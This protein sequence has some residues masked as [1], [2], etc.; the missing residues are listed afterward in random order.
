MADSTRAGASDMPQMAALLGGV[1]AQEVIKITTRQYV[2]LNGT[3]I[4][5]G[6]K[7]TSQTVN[8]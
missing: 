5:D 4:F 7:S 8:F 2:P 6:L 1:A 3:F